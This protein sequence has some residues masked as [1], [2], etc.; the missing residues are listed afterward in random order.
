MQKRIE[1]YLNKN[2]LRDMDIKEGAM[3]LLTHL[4]TK[5]IETERLILRRFEYI[6][7]E[8]MLKNW[9]SDHDSIYVF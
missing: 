4:G 9:I 6:D 3:T 8:S 1:Y 7:N 2:D 5:Q